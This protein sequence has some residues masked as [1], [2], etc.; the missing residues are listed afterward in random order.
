MNNNEETEYTS[1]TCYNCNSAFHEIDIVNS[2]DIPPT[3]RVCP[4]CQSKGVKN[5]LKL[6]DKEKLINS[7]DSVLN[8]HYNGMVLTDRMSK[9]LDDIIEKRRLRGERLI[10][11]SIISEVIEVDSYYE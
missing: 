3:W 9:I 2:L 6:R 5:D 11:K 10:V 7:V 8:L 4:D 1:H